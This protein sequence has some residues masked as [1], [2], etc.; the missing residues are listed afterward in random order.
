M[1]GIRRLSEFLVDYAKTTEVEGGF[2]EETRTRGKGGK[3]AARRSQELPGG[4]VCPLCG[5]P[6]REN[7]KAFGCSGWKD[8]CAFTL[9][10]DCLT[11]GGGP[12]LSAKLVTLLLQQKS[13][14]G[15]TGTVTLDGESIRFIPGTPEGREVSC[16]IVYRKK[17]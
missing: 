16:P 8:G 13:V 10:K 15:S 11:R 1:Q 4:A 3:T 17:T 14:R 2:P 9:W 7:E 6:V 12:A 5:K